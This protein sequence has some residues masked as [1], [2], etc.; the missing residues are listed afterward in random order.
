MPN[1]CCRPVAWIRAEVLVEAGNASLG[2]WMRNVIVESGCVL[3]LE[4]N[5]P[6]GIPPVLSGPSSHRVE[7]LL[8][9]LLGG[10]G[11]G[12]RPATVPAVAQYPYPLAGDSP[13]S[14]IVHSCALLAACTVM[15]YG[16][17][18]PSNSSEKSR[19]SIFVNFGGP[20]ANG[21]DSL[22]D[23]GPSMQSLTGGT[24][25]LISITPRYDLLYSSNEGLSLLTMINF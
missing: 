21:R 23:L 22:D 4:R 24:Y 1:S 2:S 20:G 11:H 13:L 9:G 5:A 10:W 18:V 12:P 7:L 15:H 19:G 3:C 6:L 16:G 25:D 8:P 14:L 17:W